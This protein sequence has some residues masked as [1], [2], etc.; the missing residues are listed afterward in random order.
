MSPSSTPHPPLL[1]DANDIII[2]GRTTADALESSYA[3]A[4]RH[5]GFNVTIFD[6][7]ASLRRWVRMGRLGDA[8]N[9]FWPC[10][11]WIAKA[12]RELLSQ[13]FEQ[14]PEI[15]IVGGINV[16]LAGTLAQIKSTLPKCKLVLIWPDSLLYCR[17]GTIEALPV[18]DLIATYSKATVG[19]LHSLGARRVEW[20]PLAFDPELHHPPSGG[21]PRSDAYR[22]CDASFVG[23]YTPEREKAVLS[24]VEAGLRVKVWGS[25]EWKRSARNQQVIRRHWQGRTLWGT[26]YYQAITLASTS[27]NPINPVTFPAANMRFFEILGCGGIPISAACPEMENEF[28]DGESCF[29]YG[30]GKGI[31]ETVRSVLENPEH[32]RRVAR[33]GHEQV[34][35]RHTYVHRAQQLLELLNSASHVD[36]GE[37]GSMA[38]PRY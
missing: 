3:R 37:V 12:N 34:L 11:P 6:N 27:L 10:Q 36:P 9:N 8:I 4:F 16:V 15:I 18:Y 26:D 17:S 1:M 30:P 38:E 7:Q 14:R 2:V 28:L 13:A 31:V 32:A 21:D 35:A 33:R 19:P 22:D 24:L 29:Y 5:L 23:N 20:V 25:H